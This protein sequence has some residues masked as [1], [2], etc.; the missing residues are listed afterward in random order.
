MWHEGRKIVGK[1]LQTARPSESPVPRR[2]HT[3]L[4]G[5]GA[6]H[7][8]SLAWV[9]KGSLDGGHCCTCL[10]SLQWTERGRRNPRRSTSTPLTCPPPVPVPRWWCVARPLLCRSSCV[11]SWLAVCL[12]ASVTLYKKT[13]SECPPLM[14]TKPMLRAPMSRS[15]AVPA[16][17]GKLYVTILQHYN[18]IIGSPG[19]HLP[20]LN[21]HMRPRHSH[22]MD[23][24]T[25]PPQPSKKWLDQ[26]VNRS[27]FFQ[28]IPAP[29]AALVSLMPMVYW[30][31]PGGPQQCVAGEV[32]RGCKRDFCFLWFYHYYYLQNLCVFSAFL[33][34]C[35][36]LATSM[37]HS[38]SP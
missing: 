29:A 20:S 35:V 23:F 9:L 19:V 38:L 7:P 21:G 17:T 36:F 13:A 16:H 6:F 31:G 32:S 2:S 28:G 8:P 14:A 12:S 10:V 22:A 24:P 34:F 5:W 27:K 30:P 26:Y 1:C 18:G 37:L 25:A 4:G 33:V 15:R 11:S 3:G